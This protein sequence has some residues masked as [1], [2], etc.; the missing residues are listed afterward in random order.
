MILNSQEKSL[1]ASKVRGKFC[2]LRCFLSIRNI[3][4]KS[5]NSFL[6]ERKKTTIYNML[7]VSDAI[8]DEDRGR[9]VADFAN[10]LVTK[11]VGITILTGLIDI[12]MLF[13]EKI[14]VVLNKS[15]LFKHKDNALL[16]NRFI[17]SL[18]KKN[19]IDVIN[20]CEFSLF[21]T[22][23]LCGRKLDIPVVC[24][25]FHV[26]NVFSR[27]DYLRL[28]VLRK[29]DLILS[30]SNEI[31]DYLIDEFDVCA[32]KV[33]QF[34]LPVDNSIFNIKKISSG[35]VR[36]VIKSIDVGIGSKKILFCPCN[37]GEIDFI[38][39]LIKTISTIHRDDFVCVL[40]GDFKNISSKRKELLK[41]VKRLK[42]EDRMKV[43]D[44]VSDKSAM[45]STSHAVICL[46]Q[47]R[48]SVVKTSCEAG[49]M[50]RPSIVVNKDAFTVDL[51]DG[52]TGFCVRCDNVND[53]R[54]AIVKILDLSS[55][56][57]HTMCD[58]AY[59][60]IMKH[61]VEKSAMGR[62]VN[63]IFDVVNDRICKRVN[64]KDAQQTNYF[65]KKK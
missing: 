39:R 4:G 53:I 15:L 41:Y 47:E 18:C 51:I 5:K 55:D 26:F 9:I 63:D 10:Y 64:H 11:N 44:K 43:I 32:K 16:L 57:Y 2:S 17:L 38:M 33:R 50:M 61:F 48:G 19:K 42:A 14:D 6:A 58:N 23:V 65:F 8:L 49:A 25:V 56:E 60:Y 21:K 35:R 46:Q 62:V 3:F 1:M 52:K 40:S 34:I 30:M 22:A 24:W 45:L 7:I 13:D 31:S 37:Y 27:F 29:A 28:K 59:E 20:V 54:T 36:E 12:C